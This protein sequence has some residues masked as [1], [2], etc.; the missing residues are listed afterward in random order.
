M[1]DENGEEFFTLLEDFEK[2]ERMEWDNLDQSKRD[3]CFKYLTLM[4]R[5][6]KNNSLISKTH[7]K[8][9][10]E[11]C[12]LPTHLIAIDQMDGHWLEG[13][14]KEL[15]DEAFWAITKRVDKTIAELK[16]K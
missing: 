6:M 16:N 3:N 13:S 15:T 7:K 12:D 5:L 9:M 1:K 10:L 14:N 8:W 4:K 11:N 2:D